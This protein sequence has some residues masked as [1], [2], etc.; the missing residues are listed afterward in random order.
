MSLIRSAGGE[1]DVQDGGSVEP[2]HHLIGASLYH[3]HETF[4]LVTIFEGRNLSPDCRATANHCAEAHRATTVLVVWWPGD[5]EYL[6]GMPE[7]SNSTWKQYI[8]QLRMELSGTARFRTL[9]HTEDSGVCQLAKIPPCWKIVLHVRRL[10]IDNRL[11]NSEVR[12]GLRIF[13][14]RHATC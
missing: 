13:G 14:E 12:K 9:S 2:C 6:I 8:F 3:D 5:N 1:E 4:Q 7:G 11:D 10:V